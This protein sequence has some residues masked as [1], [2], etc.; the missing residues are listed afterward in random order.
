MSRSNDIPAKAQWTLGGIAMQFERRNIKNLRIGIYA[1]HGEVRVAAPKRMAEGTVRN[2]IISRIGWIVRKRAE[3]EGREV[4]PQTQLVSGEVHYFQGRPHVL[5]V[6]EAAGRP[7]VIRVDESA[8]QLRVRP[9]ADTA[10]RFRLLNT[11]Y[12]Q[13][14]QEQLAPLV[15]RWQQRLGIEVAE[16]RIRRMRTRWGSCN[17]RARR[18]CLNLDL[19]R[20]PPQCLEYVLVHELAHFFERRHN[21][22]F[23]GFM[24]RL[25]PDW[26]AQRAE[27]NRR[28]EA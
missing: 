7:G 16:L 4:T 10:A 24:D 26:R 6:I 15:S 18:V 9:G 8:L 2:F 22:R 19:I 13:R 23:Y 3:L 11:W 27:L 1:P 28:R 12:R 17:A 21:A 20:K 5:T 14:L 25:L